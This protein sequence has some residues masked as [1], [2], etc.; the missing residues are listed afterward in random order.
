[1]PNHIANKLIINGTEE[2]IKKVMDF[3]K[4]E[5]GVIDFNNITPMPKWVYGSSPDILGIS[6]NDMELYGREN[7]S[8]G[9]AIQHWG[10]KWNAY[11]AHTL[12]DNALVWNTAWSGVPDLMRKLAWI[13]QDVTLRY[14]FIDEDWG[15]GNYG[16]WEFQ[17][18]A[19]NKTLLNE[20]EEMELAFELWCEGEVPDHLVFDETQNKYIFRED[21][22]GEDE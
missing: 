12:G 6:S 10:T 2:Q 7:T 5:E 1:M 9:W 4:S 13:F 11:D 22:G 15:G 20:K 18:T 19:A 14:T 17:G 21:R 8:I 3:L 16:V